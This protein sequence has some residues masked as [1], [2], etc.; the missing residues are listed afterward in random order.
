[1]ASCMKEK[2]RQEKWDTRSISYENNDQRTLINDNIES[3]N[4]SST[5][6]EGRLQ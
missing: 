2:D 3:F 4:Y 6:L 5:S 1:M